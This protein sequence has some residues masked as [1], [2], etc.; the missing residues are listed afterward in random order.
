MTKHINDTQ[1]DWGVC[2]GKMYKNY[3]R[4]INHPAVWLEL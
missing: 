2:K 1:R 4:G 3:S